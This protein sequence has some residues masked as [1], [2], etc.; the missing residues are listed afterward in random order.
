ML[1]KIA[2][3]GLLLLV[4]PISVSAGIGPRITLAESEHDFGDV[5]HGETPSAEISVTNTG[6]ANLILKKIGSSCGCAKAIRGSRRIAPGSTS[7]IYVQIE[8]LG[9]PPGRHSKTITVHSNDA[10]YPVTRVKLVFKVIR[11]VSISPDFLAA[12]VSESEKGAVFGAKATNHWTNPITLNGEGCTG[13]GEVTMRPKTLVVPAGGTVDF[14]FSVR[15]ETEPAR[16]YVKGIA[17]VATDDPLEKRLPVKYF[18]RLL[19]TGA[20]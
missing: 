16:P 14:Q 18:I 12:T 17:L 19:P 2:F 20:K 6:D 11:H 15:V 5:I 10:E 3:L 9:M 8:T 4:L 7:A 13:A 1:K